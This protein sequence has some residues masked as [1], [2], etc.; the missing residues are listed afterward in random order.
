MEYN[1]G[2][3]ISSAMDYAATPFVAAV[4]IGL[5]FLLGKIFG[6]W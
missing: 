2:D 5:L 3:M 4:L 1:V 6:Y